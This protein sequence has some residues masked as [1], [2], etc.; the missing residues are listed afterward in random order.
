MDDNKTNPNAKA[1]KL[2]IKTDD[3]VAG[4]VYSNFVVVHSTESEFTVD[5]MYLLPQAPQAK[6][7]S[8]VIL[9]PLQAKRLHSLLGRQ[10]AGF[11]KTFGEI[12]VPQRPMVNGS[13]DPTLN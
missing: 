12:K 6:V 3:A 1:V 7:R 2:E 10:I 13:N 5:F 11:E 4:G 9:S 8:R